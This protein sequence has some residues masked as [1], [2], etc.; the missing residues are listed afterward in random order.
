MKKSWL[1]LPAVFL[2]YAAVLVFIFALPSFGLFKK[3]VSIQFI[4]EKIPLAKAGD[5]GWGYVKR[6]QF[7]ADKD[8][9]LED[10]VVI[11]KIDK[12]DTGENYLTAPGTP[13]QAYIEEKDGRRT[14]LYSGTQFRRVDIF[15]GTTNNTLGLTLDEGEKGYWLAD[16]TY[17]PE[18][19]ITNYK[20]LRHSSF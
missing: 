2:V 14:Y 1:W 5:P 4:D 8:G 3:D 20:Y 15:L 9:E 16:F 11:A 19:K 18:G 6:V 13:W 12:I 7:D 10:I 17:I